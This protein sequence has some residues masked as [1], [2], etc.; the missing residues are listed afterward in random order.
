METEKTK[1]APRQYLDVA[2]AIDPE[3]WE[4][5]TKKMHEK[6][7]TLSETVTNALKQYL[8]IK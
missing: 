4:A 3:L 1:K 5:V 8:K 7:L 6:Q 2:F